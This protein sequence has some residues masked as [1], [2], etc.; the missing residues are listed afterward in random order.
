MSMQLYRL[1]LFVF[2]MDRPQ[3]MKNQTKKNY[4]K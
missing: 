4:R 2:E 1:L 3:I